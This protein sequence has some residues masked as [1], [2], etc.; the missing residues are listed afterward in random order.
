MKI[1][2]IIPAFDEEKTVGNVVAA[3][4][5]A[6]V[7]D[8]VIVVNDGST[9]RT[10][11]VARAAGARVIDLQRN[12]GKGGAMKAGADST[13]AEILLF[14]DADLTGLTAQHLR[15]LLEPVV[16]DRADMTVGL[17]DEGRF[18]TDMAQKITP[19]LSGQRAMR[20]SIITSV[21][22]IEH[23]RYGVEMALSRYAEKHALRVLH[24]SLKNVAQVMK[25][26]KRGLLRGLGARLRMYWE[27]LRWT[28]E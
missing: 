4:L 26:E 2:A 17:F 12:V 7:T 22:Y 15:A 27:I 16:A 8:E 28:R 5:S 18:A 25:E 10:S 11:E 20:R 21:P 13:D 3:V 19:F 23:T 14:L 24:V 9:D 6:N 1:A